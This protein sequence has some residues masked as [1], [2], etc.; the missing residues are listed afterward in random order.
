MRAAAGRLLFTNDVANWTALSLFANVHDSTF[1]VVDAMLS[2]RY[3]CRR[4]GRPWFANEASSEADSA[5]SRTIQHPPSHSPHSPRLPLA[6]I[7]TT[8]RL[9][10]QPSLERH[11]LGFQGEPSRLG[12]RAETVAPQ[13]KGLTI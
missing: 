4:L 6:R 8:H 10:V 9:C 2:E 12:S 3:R 7:M 5:H 11:A 13:G 1:R